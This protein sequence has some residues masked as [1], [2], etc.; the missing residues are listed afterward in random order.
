[1]VRISMIRD[2]TEVLNQ[3]PRRATTQPVEI[4]MKRRAFLAR[5]AT[6]ALAGAIAAPA[7]AQAPAVRWRLATSWPKSLDAM[8]GAADEMGRRVTQ[9]TEK[10]F[11]ITAFAGGEIVP[12]LQVLDA[13]QNGTVECGHTLTSFYIGKNTAYAFDSGLPFGLNNRQQNAWMYHG[14]GLELVRDMFRKVGVYPIPCGNVGVQ[15]GGFFRKEIN[16]LDD[17]KGLKFRIGGLGGMILSKLGVVPQQ[18]AT[19]DIYP[20]L[21]RGTIDGAEWIGPYDDEK[22]GLHKVAKF[23]YTPGW[24]EGSAQVTL[25]VNLRAFE[26]LSEVHR[27]TLEAACA[28]QT[29]SMMAKYDARNPEALRRLVAGGVQ[30][31]PFPRAVMDAAYKASLETFDEL[32]AKNE[33]FKR[34]YESWQ[35]FLGDSNTWFRVAEN[36][37]DNYRYTMSGQR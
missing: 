29:L 17:L 14:G 35:K 10:K 24:W 7:L 34:I 1:M 4:D 37:L 2:S 25:L 6:G 19:A 20:A 26:A 15:M 16:S 5:A 9:L 18:I 32:S 33:D 36:N 31:R 8:H 3:L 22:L 23:Y 12:P 30:L 11:E 28:E 21:E 27:A 13:V